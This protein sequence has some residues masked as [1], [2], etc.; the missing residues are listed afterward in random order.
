MVALHSAVLDSITLQTPTAP[1]RAPPHA[2]TAT[3]HLCTAPLGLCGCTTRVPERDRGCSVCALTS[4][5]S[6]WGVEGGHTRA[7]SPERSFSGR[8]MHSCTHTTLHSSPRSLSPCMPLSH[9]PTAASAPSSSAGATCPA[10]HTR[11][12]TAPSTSREEQTGV[13][14]GGGG[15]RQQCWPP[16]LASLLRPLPHAASRC[17]SSRYVPHTT[18]LV[19]V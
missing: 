14:T 16:T 2:R 6:W 12:L 19:Q 3:P 17:T 4:L 5:A 15:V 7:P 8:R 13:S 18:G 1:L 11:G 10:L 9:H